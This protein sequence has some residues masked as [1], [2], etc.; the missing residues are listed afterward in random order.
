MFFDQ[1]VT[2]MYLKARAPLAAQ[3]QLEAHALDVPG[4]RP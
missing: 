1:V 2:M 3:L 4:P